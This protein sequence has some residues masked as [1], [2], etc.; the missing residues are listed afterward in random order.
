[1]DREKLFIKLM[2]ESQGVIYTLVLAMVHNGSDAEDIT[3]ET[4]AV[5]WKKFDMFEPGTNFTAWGCKIARIQAL[6]F[7]DKTCHSKVFISEDLIQTIADRAESKLQTVSPQTEAL[8]NC[9][10]KLPK[11]EYDL[12]QTRYE[13]RI[14]TKKLADI[15]GVSLHVMY[16]VMS[17]IHNRLRLCVRRALAEQGDL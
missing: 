16:S 13:G 15:V 12:I 1:M 5:M 2:R 7:I 8:R 17:K 6:R 3:Q 11:K 4:F 14:T 9:L 10:K